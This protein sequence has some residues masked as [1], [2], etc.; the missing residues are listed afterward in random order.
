MLRIFECDTMEEFV[1]LTGNS[2]RGIVH[3]DDLEEVEQSIWYQ[4]QES[5]YDLDYVEYRIVTKYGNVRWVEDYGHFIHSETAGNFYYVFISDATEKVTRRMAET[6]TIINEGKAKEQKLQ[7]LIE[8]Y[9]KERKLIRQE[10][11]QRL[12]VIEGLSVNYDSILYADLD[13]D[14]VLPYRLSTRLERQFE[15]RLQVRE[16]ASVFDRLCQSMGAPRRPRTRAAKDFRRV[17]QKSAR[18]QSDVLS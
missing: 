12:E 17:Y 10:H 16:I 15:Q 5:R 14:K 18:K 11:L 2:F 9:D 3:P 6:A 8:E 7:S 4:I 13:G 1:E